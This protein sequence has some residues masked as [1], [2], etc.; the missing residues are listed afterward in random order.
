MPSGGAVCIMFLVYF[1]HGEN[2][3]AAI[4]VKTRL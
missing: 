1:I 3:A 2:S 4:P